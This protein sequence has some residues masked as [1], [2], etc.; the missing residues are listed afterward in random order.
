MLGRHGA[1]P[2]VE[3]HRPQPF[4][5][6][7][8]RRD[9]VAFVRPQGELDLA[10]VESLRAALDGIENAERLVLDLRGLTFLD[11]T[12]LRLL[13]TLHQRSHRDGFQLTL[14]APAGPADRAIELSGLDQVLPFAA[15]DDAAAFA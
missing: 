12:G 10:T 1:A 3:P 11:S 14:I 8:Q 13:V 9:D 15:A 4:A 6:D 5:V 7:V 2:A